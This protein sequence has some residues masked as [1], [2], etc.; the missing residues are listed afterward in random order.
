MA[1]TVTP[2][3]VE[4]VVSD[5]LPQFGVDESQITRDATFEELDVDSLDLAELSQIIEDEFGVQL[6]GEDVAQI[7][8]VGDAVDLVVSRAA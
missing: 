7:K 5:A 3:Q 1:T 6:K 2:D 4:K 8:T